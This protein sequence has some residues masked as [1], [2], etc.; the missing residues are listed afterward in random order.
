MLAQSPSSGQGQAA[1]YAPGTS[2]VAGQLAGVTG[3]GGGI[4]GGTV[5]NATAGN[6]LPFEILQP[7]LCV[8]F[9]IALYGIFPSRN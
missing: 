2:P 4:T 6:S 8:T 1:V 5:A 9:I 3:G 7:Y